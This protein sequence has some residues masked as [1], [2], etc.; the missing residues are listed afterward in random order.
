MPSE[1]DHRTPDRGLL[2]RGAIGA[3]LFV[4]VF[5]IEDAVRAIRPPGYNP[6]RQ[7]VSSLA[8]GPFGW[9][10]VANLLVTGVLLLAFAVGLR[11][12]LR[13]YHGGFWAPALLGLVAIGLIGAGVFTT[14][15]LS[16]YPPGTLALPAGPPPPTL[17]CMR[18]SRP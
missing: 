1:R 13:R 11:P 10:Q 8:I 7:P 2:W 3:P 12:A 17:P 6:I 4:V 16:G 15:P 5:L 9:I 18:R 14:D